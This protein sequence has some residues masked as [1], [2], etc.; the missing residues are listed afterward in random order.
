VSAKPYIKYFN[1]LGIHHIG[2]YNA[3]EGYIGY[4]DILHYANDEAQAPY[5]LLVNHGI[6]YE[7]IPFTA[8]NFENGILKQGAKSKPL[9]EITQQDIDS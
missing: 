9:R 7:F 2:A 8:E 4:Q 1:E 3:S 5:Q 6:F